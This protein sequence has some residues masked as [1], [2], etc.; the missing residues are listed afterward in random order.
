[1]IKHPN[2]PADKLCRK[3]I[4]GFP[5]SLAHLAAIEMNI[6]LHQLTTIRMS[7]NIAIYSKVSGWCSSEVMS[8]LISFLQQKKGGK[9]KPTSWVHKNLAGNFIVSLP[10]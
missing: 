4:N 1:M 3:V 10:C 5:S 9:K 6:P 7:W 2:S 8:V